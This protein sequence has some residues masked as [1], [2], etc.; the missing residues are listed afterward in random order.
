[1]GYLRGPLSDESKA[2]GLIQSGPSLL[3]WPMRVLGLARI[4]WAK[5]SKQNSR[6]CAYQAAT[7]VLPA[8]RGSPMELLNPLRA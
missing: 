8:F 6:V 3:R 7:S 5:G 1:M 4:V 2:E